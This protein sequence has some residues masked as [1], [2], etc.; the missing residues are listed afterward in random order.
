MK[1]SEDLYTR[2]QITYP[3]TETDSFP[4]DTNIREILNIFINT[5]CIYTPYVEKLLNLNDNQLFPN[6]GG[7]SD[8]AH[9]PIIPTKC[10]PYSS[11]KQI[12]TNDEWKIYDLIVR[13]FLACCSQ[14]A[15]AEET[16]IYIQYGTENFYTRGILVKQYGFLDIYPWQKWKNNLLPYKFEINTTFT[17]TEFFIVQSSTTPPSLLKEVDLINLMDNHGIGTDATI[18][19]HI[20][21]IINRNYIYIDKNNFFIPSNLGKALVF[22]CEAI[23]LQLTFPE[24]RALMEKAII[25]IS[26]GIYTKDTVINQYI[27]DADKILQ[28]LQSNVNTVISYVFKELNGIIDENM[29][30]K[31]IPCNFCKNIVE[32]LFKWVD[33]SKK[34]SYTICYDCLSN[35][36]VSDGVSLSKES[37]IL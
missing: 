10:I 9:Q 12:Y 8:E 13:S 31:N 2:G 29:Y 15:L 16:K 25:D 28:Y 30:T 34:K 11:S 33:S 4:K 26:N 18:S 3:R 23:N 14:D 19:T 6:N 27:H 20:Q 17:P 24:Q 35:V 7:H 5:K 32:Y 37:I 21:T 1:I 36:T 22:A